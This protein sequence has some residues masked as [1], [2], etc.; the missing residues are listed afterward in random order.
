MKEMSGIFLVEKSI[1]KEK[2]EDC[3]KR[4][5][6]EEVNIDITNIKILKPFNLKF[7][8][9]PVFVLVYS[10]NISCDSQFQFHMNTLSTSF[11]QRM[12]LKI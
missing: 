2:V 11:L 10:A 8:K 7:N 9:V 12:K 1:L 5:V 3:L 6:K 4:E